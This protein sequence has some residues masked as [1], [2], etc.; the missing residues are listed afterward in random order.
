MSSHTFTASLERPEASGTWTYLV[1]PFKVEEVFGARSQV[2]VRGTVNGAPYRSSLMPR[3]DGSHYMVVNKEV[4]DRAGV[5]HGDTVDVVME[6]DA[7]PRTLDIPPEL[8]EALEGSREASETFE[9]LSYSHLKEYVDYIREA[10]KEETKLRRIRKAI[11]T[12]AEG[13]SLK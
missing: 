2:K 11:E 12:L 4:R 3:G 5:S 9:K 6:V 8:V 1:V 13:R 10:K 7:E